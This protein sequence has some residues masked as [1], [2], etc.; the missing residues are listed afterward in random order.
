MG[1]GSSV[2]QASVSEPSQAKPDKQK[3][4]DTKQTKQ[5][6]RSTSDVSVFK[7]INPPGWLYGS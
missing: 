6:I 5:K 1:C 4:S 7:K 2:A 3:A